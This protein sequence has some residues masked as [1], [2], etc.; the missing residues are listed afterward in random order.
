MPDKDERLAEDT[1]YALGRSHAEYNRLIEQA[2]L[3]RP[4]TER[5]LLAAGICRGM[6]VLDVGC[7]VGDVSFLVAAIVGPEGSVVGVDL[8]AE[9]L[10]V[11][12]KR[13][14]EQEIN[15]VELHCSDARSVDPGRLFDAAVGRFVL[16]FM[17]DPT[18]ALRLIAERVRPGGVV[19]FHEFD[20]RVTTA[21]AMNQPVLARLQELLARTFE[22]SGARLEIGA[23]LYSRMLDAGLEPE[24]RPLA[25]IAVRMGQGEIAYRR[26]ALFARSMTLKM[27]EFGLATEEDILDLV[28]HQLRDE[29]A[30]ACEFTPL[31]WLMIAQWARKPEVAARSA[32]GQ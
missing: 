19:A 7:G 11:A 8:D 9:A 29:L 27:V 16:M 31:S 24:P 32:H 30:P 25:E 28:D 20:A 6:R 12:E 21:A 13:R 14:G 2:E 17:S 23:E 22:R 15:N 4:L 1:D 3:F 5:M 18:A 26:W 10:K